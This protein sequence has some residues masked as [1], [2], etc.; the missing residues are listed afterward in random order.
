[1]RRI[2]VLFSNKYAPSSRMA[3]GQALIYDF[4]ATARAGAAN[5]KGVGADQPGMFRVSA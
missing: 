5:E 4:H 2:Q 1:M 3:Q